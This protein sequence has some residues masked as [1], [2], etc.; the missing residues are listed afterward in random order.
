MPDPMF[1]L[2]GRVAAVT[3][4]GTHIGRAIAEVL[5]QHGATVHLLGRRA[6]VLDD[7]AADLQ[8]QGLDCRPLP[9]D[10]SVDE[11]VARAVEAIVGES[12]QLDVMVCNA[13]GAAASRLFPDVIIEEF[14]ETMRACVDTAMICAQHAAREMIPRRSGRIVL[15]GS[16]HGELGGDPRLY[17]P[18]FARAGV[19][20]HAAKGAV[21]NLA[22]ALACELGEHAITVN[23]LS[24][25]QIPYPDRTSQTIERFALNAPLG[26]NGTPDDL[27]GAAL[28]LASDAGAWITGHNL[29]VD[30]GWS[31]W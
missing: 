14:R 9:C 16:I 5:A 10:A 19:S 4:G 31:A 22:R 11:D 2:D 18:D 20:Y 6:D 1:D 15:I 25:G 24:P 13:G 27:K 26:R 30:G 29:I 3:G 7:T 17:G 21:V 12:G 23:C 28:L 8:A